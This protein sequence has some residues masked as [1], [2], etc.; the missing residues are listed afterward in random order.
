MDKSVCEQRSWK[1]ELVTYW[2]SWQIWKL[3]SLEYKWQ[4]DWNYWGPWESSSF[5]CTPKSEDGIEVF[6]YSYFEGPR[7]SVSVMSVPNSSC[8]MWGGTLCSLK[9]FKNLMDTEKLLMCPELCQLIYKTEPSQES[10]EIV[11]NLYLR[12]LCTKNA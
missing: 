10:V 12:I 6:P 9:E 4:V 1:I 11:L 8:S 5:L 3:K 2:C 7:F